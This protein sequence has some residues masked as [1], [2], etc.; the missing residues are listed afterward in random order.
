MILLDTHALL[1]FSAEDDA[2]GKRSTAVAREALTSDR[3]HVSAVSFWEIAMLTVKGRLEGLDTPAEQRLRI[4]SSGIRE[5]PLTG[6]IALLA[7]GLDGLHGD[8]A[9]RFIVATA[10]CHEATLVT[11]DSRLLRWRHPV[12]RQDAAK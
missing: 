11:A 10:I 3:L 1:W 9:D 7:G 4:L 5:V 2:L 6:D 8:P 12:K